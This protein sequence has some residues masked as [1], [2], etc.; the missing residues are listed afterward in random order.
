M[1]TYYEK[2]LVSS[3]EVPEK[4]DHYTT[5]EGLRWFHPSKGFICLEGINVIKVVWWLK[6][7]PSPKQEVVELLK[8]AAKFIPLYMPTEAHR[9]HNKLKLDILKYLSEKGEK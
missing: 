9:E 7:V 5:S 3:G 1:K 8:R 4:E 6:P 2:I